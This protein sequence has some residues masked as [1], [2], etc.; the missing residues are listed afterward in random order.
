MNVLHHFK[1]KQELVLSKM[2]CKQVIFEINKEEIPL[3]SKYFKIIKEV[4]SHRPNRT[5][6]LGEK[7]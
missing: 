4:K 7:L 5:I 6:L 3:I 2:D 1:G